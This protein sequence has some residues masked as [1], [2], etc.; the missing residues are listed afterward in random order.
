MSAFLDGLVDPIVGRDIEEWRAAIEAKR[1]AEAR[2]RAREQAASLAPTRRISA[3][4][5][6]KPPKPPRPT[7]AQ[8]TLTLWNNGTTD[9]SAIAA[10]LNLTLPTIRAH[11]R[12]AGI[13]PPRPQRPTKP[14]PP[15]TPGQ[16]SERSRAL[17]D[18]I[19]ELYAEGELGHKAIGAALGCSGST[20]A[21]HLKS[22]GV[23]PLRARG[24]RLTKPTGSKPKTYEPDLV[25]KV[26]ALAAARHTQLEIAEMT[27][28]GRKVIYRVMRRH[29]IAPGPALAREPRDHAA[30]LKE[31]MKK[32]GI[33]SHEVRAWAVAAGKPISDRGL[34]PRSVVEAF[35][36]T[37]HIEAA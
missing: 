28:L 27:G 24:H 13:T 2:R 34:P 32:S 15:R 6:V 10:E 22:R 35:L 11:L 23:P 36:A 20:V 8:Q 26:R 21:F 19:V 3:P 9:L 37:Q 33:S 12:T 7:R 16:R 5:R 30:G 29:G 17:G 1:D 31:L 25:E 14:K 18:R 4:T